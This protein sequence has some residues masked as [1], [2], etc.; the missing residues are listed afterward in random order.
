[1]YCPGQLALLVKKGRGAD[2][3]IAVQQ[4]LA[5]LCHVLLLVCSHSCFAWRRLLSDRL[6]WVMSR[7][8]L[9]APMASPAAFR[10][11][12][13]VTATSITVPSLRWRT[14][15]YCSIRSPRASCSSCSRNSTERPGGN[16]TSAGRPTTSAA[17]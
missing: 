14:V 10:I 17:V 7:A 3:K 6:A 8:M 2:H 12:E 15:S 4:L 11:G 16:R 13:I 1:M 5:H 9:E